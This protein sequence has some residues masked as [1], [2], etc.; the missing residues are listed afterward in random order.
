M[1]INRVLLTS[2]DLRIPSPAI[3][4]YAEREIISTVAKSVS[5]WQFV[6]NNQ[7]SKCCA[8]AMQL[9]FKARDRGSR[10]ALT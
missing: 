1:R 2:T 10:S 4:G 8:Q 6:L 3:S 5:T 9:I 7:A